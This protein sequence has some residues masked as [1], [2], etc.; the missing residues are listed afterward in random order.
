[1]E[2]ITLQFQSVQL[3]WSFV[4]SLKLREFYISSK[5]ICLT[6]K[7]GEAYISEALTYYKARIIKEKAEVIS[8][9]N[10][11]KYNV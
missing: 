4:K 8:T 3:L 10:F 11:K 1:M 6:C 5:K 9:K 7:L 2:R